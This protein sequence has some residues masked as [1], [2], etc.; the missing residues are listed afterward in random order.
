MKGHR[1]HVRRKMMEN[2]ENR[3]LFYKNVYEDQL[4]PFVSEFLELSHYS[5]SLSLTLGHLDFS[6]ST[7]ALDQ[8]R[9]EGKTKEGASKEE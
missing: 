8:E 7:L 1:F 5:L 6:W 9:Q 2:E 4:V 3:G